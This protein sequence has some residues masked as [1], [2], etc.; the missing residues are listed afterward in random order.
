MTKF[1]EK[2][3]QNYWLKW[4]EDQG[5]TPLVS[6]GLRIPRLQGCGLNLPEGEFI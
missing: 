4:D 6:K 1:I 2:E 5:K 3:P